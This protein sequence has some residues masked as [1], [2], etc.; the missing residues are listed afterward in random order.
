MIQTVSFRTVV[1]TFLSTV[2]ILLAVL[3]VL[4]QARHL[5]LGPQLSITEEPETVVNSKLP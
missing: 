5:L 4:F 2:M 1:L 3:F